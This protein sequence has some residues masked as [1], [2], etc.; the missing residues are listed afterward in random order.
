MVT[1][2]HYDSGI[3]AWPDKARIAVTLTFDFQGGEDVRPLADGKIDHEEYTQHEYGPNTAIWRLLRILEEEGVTATFLTCGGIA[4]RYPDAVK[5]I[6]AGGHEIAGHGYHH[7]VARDLTR[8]QE[9]EVMRKTTAM[10]RMRTGQVP[11]GWRSCTQSPNSIALL[12]EHGYLWNSNSFSHDLPFLWEQDGKH[13]VELPRQPFG[14]GRT[15]D[16]DAGDPLRTLTVWKGMF[17]DFSDESRRHATYVPFQFHPYIS[18]RPGRAR[19]VRAIIQ[20]MKSQQGVWFARGS[21]VARWC[22]DE[23]FKPGRATPREVARASGAA[24]E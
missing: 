4:E 23:L 8:E 6:V 19:T 15:Y 16:D 20:H 11:V 21:E 12:M 5:A 1:E 2:Y 14:D 22:L 10:I 13:L 9:H 17:D 3:F 7:E 18:G 24:A